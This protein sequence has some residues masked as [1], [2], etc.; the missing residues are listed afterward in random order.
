MVI[1]TINFLIM[2]IL[3]IVIYSNIENLIV[4]ELAKNAMNTAA[5]TASFIERD[6][7]PYKKLS[8][9]QV[10]DRGLYDEEY[11]GSMLILFQKLKK[12]TGAT[13]IFTE[14]KVA[15]DKVQY[16]LDGEVPFS[17]GF[18]PIGAEDGIEETE[19]RAFNEGRILATD[20]IRDPV[21]GDFLTG[22]APIIDRA[23]NKVVGLV[24]VDFSLNYV[25]SLISHIKVLIAVSFYTIAVFSTCVIY[26]IMVQKYKSFERDQ[27][28]DLF[29]KGYFDQ[30]IVRIMDRSRWIKKS[31]S[32]AV[33]DIDDFKK[34]N[35]TLGHVAGDEILRSVGKLMKKNLRYSDFCFRYGGDELVLVL[36][37][38]E[39]GGA[40]Q[41][42]ERI[43]TSI[44]EHAFD[45]GGKTIH[46]TI[47]VGLVQ[48][49]G[50]MGSEELVA[51]ADRE[52]YI[53]KNAG[54]NRV[55]IHDQDLDAHIGD[56]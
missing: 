19:L 49:D 31:F 48:W 35:D 7:E 50:Q 53:S 54:K 41:I 18:S 21:W 55:S 14:K 44:G 30:Q 33:I 1:L 5:T 37:D 56:S 4:K 36:P 40:Q 12:D 29:S 51:C 2:S 13:F 15:E 38:T 9:V 8:A 32:L 34:I 26:I 47:S 11:Y 10:Y 46:I 25:Q 42:C 39:V 22:F 27:L 43:K 17:G 24:G 3:Y 28:T 52:M 16:I 23:D 45:I 6:I 20:M